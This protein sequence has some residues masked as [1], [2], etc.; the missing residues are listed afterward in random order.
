MPKTTAY[1]PFQTPNRRPNELYNIYTPNAKN[2]I[3]TYRNA[4]TTTGTHSGS[5]RNP[6]KIVLLGVENT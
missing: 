2:T 6:Q 4:M 5:P 1:P 3:K